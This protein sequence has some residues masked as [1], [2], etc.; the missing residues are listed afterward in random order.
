MMEFADPRHPHQHK[1]ASAITTRCTTS[2]F[3]EDMN[4]YIAKVRM[5]VHIKNAV[6]SSDDVVFCAR[7]FW[8]GINSRHQR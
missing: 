4:D 3:N 7:A 2:D 6:V 1:Q 8:N 5:D